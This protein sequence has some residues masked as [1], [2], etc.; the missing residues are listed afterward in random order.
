MSVAAHRFGGM[1]MVGELVGAV[2]AGD[3]DRPAEPD[4]AA[5]LVALLTVAGALLAA[6]LLVRTLL[7]SVVEG[8]VEVAPVF[9][10]V[11]VDPVQLIRTGHS[12]AVAVTASRGRSVNSARTDRSITTLRPLGAR[13]AA[14]IRI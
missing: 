6:S 5:V 1:L 11:V 14:A 12:K 13:C 7:G 2:V 8:A 10:A 9:D 4:G 3:E